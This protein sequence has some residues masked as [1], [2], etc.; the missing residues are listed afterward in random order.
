[1]TRRE[2]PA[3]TIKFI[4]SKILKCDKKEV[5]LKKELVNDLG[6]DS[7]QVL[8]IIIAIERELNIEID[9]G[10]IGD[11]FGELKVKDLIDAANSAVQLRS[12][13]DYSRIK[14]TVLNNMVALGRENV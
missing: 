9:D 2:N 1:M 8:Q 14:P 11:V 4:I 10:R 7:L 6:A 12:S 13:R 5:L 3:P